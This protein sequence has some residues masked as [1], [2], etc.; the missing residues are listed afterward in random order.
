MKF[1]TISEA[2]NHYRNSS[3]ED[4]ERRAA[5]IKG[6]IESDPE[7][8]VAA[9]NIEIGG[10][11]EAKA[12]LMEK[13]SQQAGFN[14]ITGMEFTQRASQ[15]AVQGDVLASA[16][17][18]SAFYKTMLGH[19]LTQHE[20]AAWDRAQTEQRADAFSTTTNT[21]AVIPTQTLNEVITKA[22]TM[23]GLLGVCRG[24]NIPAKLSI[25]VGTPS[26]KAVWN[27]EGAEVESQQPTVASVNFGSFEIIKVFSISASV[28]RMSVPAFESYL[29]EELASCVLATLADGVVNGTGSGQGTGILPGITWTDGINAVQYTGGTTTARTLAYA[30]VTAAIAKLKRGYAIGAVFAMNNATL[31]TQVYGLT[32]ANKR[33]IFIQ[34]AQSDTIG[35][36]LGFPVVVDDYLPDDV[37]LYGNFQYMGYNLPEGIAVE[38]ST[39]SSFKSGRIDYRA[40]AIADCKPIV[41]EAFVKLYL[42]GE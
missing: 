16:E 12:N 28:R 17:Y 25:P 39:Q 6:L 34:D 38:A 4:I 10:L 11:Q 37:I 42:A 15:E 32:D 40:M 22:R 20:Q 8:D 24:F 35:K 13:R 23:G 14:P 9:L 33:P 19:K 27:T 31:F 2:F 1:T 5:E 29:A 18:R 30:D 7:A 41:G 26:G 21:A 3:L 36:L